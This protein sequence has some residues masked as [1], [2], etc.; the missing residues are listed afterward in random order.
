MSLASLKVLVNEDCPVYDYSNSKKIIKKEEKTPEE[1]KVEKPSHKGIT[2]DGCGISPI[3]GCRYKCAICQ[4]FDYCEF[5]EE[6]FYSEHKHP[7]IKI[8][9]PEMK[10]ASIKCVVKADCPVY[11]KEK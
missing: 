6:K 3:V 5:C 1:P 9:N 2:C 7:F 8:Y 10:I 11:Q 4:N